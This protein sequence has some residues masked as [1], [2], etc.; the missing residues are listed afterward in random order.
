[1]VDSQLDQI[2]PDFNGTQLALMIQRVVVASYQRKC[3]KISGD[4]NAYIKALEA[5]KPF[6]TCVSS[7]AESEK[8]D[9]Q[10]TLAQQSGDFKPALK[11]W[12]FVVSA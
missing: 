8:F 5:A 1:M 6:E 11:K 2:G 3:K 10:Y 4:D 12:V 9:E 7:W